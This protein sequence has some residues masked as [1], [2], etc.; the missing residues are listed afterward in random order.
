MV[1]LRL[2][3]QWS[4]LFGKGIRSQIISLKYLKNCFVEVWLR[5]QHF[6]VVGTSYFW[7]GF[8]GSL[9]WIT[10]QLGWWVVNNLSIKFGSDPI[11]GLCAPYILPND[12]REYL[13]DLGISPLA[14]A[15]NLDYGTV[16]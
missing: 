9:S 16:G 2:K 5:S 12:L 15:H 11:V 4:I 13:E 10:C 7:N 1:A 8:I 14:Q 6:H 3:I